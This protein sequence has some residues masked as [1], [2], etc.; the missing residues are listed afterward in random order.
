MAKGFLDGCIW[1]A[2]SEGT[3]D[4]EFTEAVE[5]FFSPTEA[6]AVDEMTYNYTAYHGASREAG[7]GVWDADAGTLTRTPV[8]STNS[9]NLVNFAE[10]PVVIMGGPL[11]QDMHW[12]VIGDTTVGSP[13]NSIEHDVDFSL[14]AEIVT[15][16]KSI[17]VT[18]D[19]GDGTQINFCVQ[20]QESDDTVIIDKPIEDQI[21]NGVDGGSTFT[22]NGKTAWNLDK[23]ASAP[24]LVHAQMAPDTFFLI[25]TCQIDSGDLTSATKIVYFFSDANSDGDV[26]TAESITAGRAVTHGV[27]W[28]T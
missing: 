8:I 20:I 11:A 7:Y 4:F 12:E 14:Y 6:G 16:F 17:A 2:Q 15:H 19:S 13:T 25:N 28:P 1:Q 22:V 5:S 27:R 18:E 23:T 24:V 10:P 3:G 21:A 26:A 9:N